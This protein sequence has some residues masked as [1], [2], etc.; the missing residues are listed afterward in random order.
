M[1]D[2]LRAVQVSHGLLLYGFSVAYLSG[3]LFAVAGMGA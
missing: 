1:D 2:F 3:A